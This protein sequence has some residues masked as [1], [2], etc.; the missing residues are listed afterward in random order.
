METKQPVW[1]ILLVDDDEDE[2]ALARGMLAAAAD[3]YQLDWRG[4]FEEGLSALLAG[5]YDAALID[6]FLGRGTGVELIHA[7][8]AQGCSFPLILITGVAREEIDI[9]AMQAGATDYL[10]RVDL[11]PALLERALRYAIRN[12]RLAAEAQARV[13]SERSILKV[14]IDSAPA[15]ILMTDAA[16]RFTILNPAAAAFFPPSGISGDA[17]GPASGYTLHHADGSP[18][19]PD[20]LPLPRALRGETTTGAAVTIRHDSGREVAALVNA[21]PIRDAAGQITG[22]VAV[23]LDVS[24]QKQAE[25]ALRAAEERFQR[26]LDTTHTVMFTADRDLRYTWVYNSHLGFRPEDLVGKRDDEILAPEAAAVVMEPKLEVLRT[27]QPVRREVQYTIGGKLMAYQAAY[28]PILSPLGEVIGLNAVAM[29]IT[30]LVQL[31]NQQAQDQARIE[32]QRNILLQREQERAQI[33]RDLHDGPLQ[34]LIGLSFQMQ[35]LLDEESDPAKKRLMAEMK[36]TVAQLITELRSYAAELRPPVL[37]SLGLKRAIEAHLKEFRARH[38]AIQ[39]TFQASEAGSALEDSAGTALYRIYQELM[40]NVVRHAGA[41]A[42]EVIL[43]ITPR[44][45][46]LEV[47]DNG[48]GFA[49]PKSWVELARQKHLGLVGIRERAEAVG[50]AVEIQARAGRGTHVRVSIPRVVNGHSGG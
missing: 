23:L 27:G 39:V 3:E 43:E 18:Y 5:G 11:T 41:S 26:V 1:R 31:R 33:A 50:G 29:D 28:D 9:E 34:D 12:H 2:F 47:R 25:R 45:V 38:P 6:Y 37:V 36:Q 15:G 40:N 42:V 10:N 17:A 35:N 48:Q 16:G 46:T 30:G 8:R 14:I 49:M 44:Q 32:I 20:D 7:A 13:E 21:A 19:Q 4:T 22:A 24:E